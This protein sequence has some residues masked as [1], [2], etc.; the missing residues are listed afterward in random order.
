MPTWRAIGKQSFSRPSA[1]GRRGA[2]RQL[3]VAVGLPTLLLAA[4]ATVENPARPA[5]AATGDVYTVA[6]NGTTGLSGDGG[7][8]ISAELN[9][10]SGVAAD[11]AG[12][13]YIADSDSASS[14]NVGGRVLKVST[15]GTI[16]TVAGNLSG[17]F[18]GTLFYPAVLA[19]DSAGNL[20]MGNV[21][22]QQV[23][24]LTTDGTI[25]LVAGNGTA[26]FSG[27][28][29]PAISAELT[30]PSGVAVDTAGNVYIADLNNQRVRKVTTDGTITTVA[31]NGTAG[32]SGD[33]KPAISAELNDPSGVAVDSAGNLYIADS[34][35]QRVRKVTT[36][37]TITTWAGNGTA[38]FSG[39]KV[40]ATTAELNHP[41]GVAVDNAGNLYIGD[42][43]NQRVRKVST[44]NTITTV[45]GNGTAG[46]SGDGGAATSAELNQ[47]EGVAVDSTGNLYIADSNN[48]RV[49]MV[50]GPNGGGLPVTLPPSTTTTTTAPITTTTTAPPP[51][52]AVPLRAGDFLAVF[53][54]SGQDTGAVQACTSGFAVTL[55]GTPWALTT[56]HCRDRQLMNGTDTDPA[57][58][59]SIRGWPVPSPQ[60]VGS[61]ADAL[62]LPLYDAQPL[63]CDRG[64]RCNGNSA[65]D[66][67]IWQPDPSYV[68]TPEIHVVKNGQMIPEPVIRYAPRQTYAP[69]KQ[70]EQMCAMGDSTGHELC[71]KI[72]GFHHVDLGG[73][74]KLGLV[75]WISTSPSHPCPPPGGVTNGICEGDSGGPVYTYVTN[76][77]GTSGVVAL[78]I[79]EGTQQVCKGLFKKSCQ[80][81]N[82]FVPMASIINDL[83]VSLLTEPGY[84]TIP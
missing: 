63:N 5:A 29:K 75:S 28:G 54:A 51:P 15:D 77:D 18:Q 83:G 80:Y 64:T 9:G 82:Y 49:R 60:Y 56:D 21:I 6:G 23:W 65:I 16:T 24:K 78:G 3:V 72:D 17:F 71:G 37:G 7:P 42:F 4:L 67:M 13:L 69:W 58:Y 43:N 35:N 50:S 11:S 1:T 33:G 8:A 47:P 52:P 30:Q 68:P 62:K 81:V 53:R 26:G 22:G 10:P 55:K 61:A 70:G 14:T 36:D 46:F 27:D 48:H 31:G 32:F 41:I 20:Y 40:P 84:P 38:G 39:E 25:T 2:V 12:N 74:R 44:D 79:N 19:V 66:A 57:Q 73:G 34:N 76:S 45:A 59:I